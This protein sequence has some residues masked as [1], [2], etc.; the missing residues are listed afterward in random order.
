MVTGLLN[1]E[2]GLLNLVFF[3]RTKTVI[4][5]SSDDSF[6]PSGTESESESESAGSSVFEEESSGENITMIIFSSF[7]P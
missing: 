2:T 7:S 1:S 6:I 5:E 4:E 3:Q